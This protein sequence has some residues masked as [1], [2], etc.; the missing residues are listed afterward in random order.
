MNIQSLGYRINF[1]F[2]HFDGEVVDK[3][4]YTVIRTP[5]NFGYFWGN[6]LLFANPPQAGDLERWQGLFAQEIGTPPTINHITLG[7]DSPEGIRGE[8]APFLDAGFHLH[9][10]LIMSTQ[11]V[12]PPPKWNDA[13]TIRPIQGDHEWEQAF[14]ITLRCFPGEEFGESYV[15]FKRWEMERFR[16]MTEA[17]RGHWF[18]AFLDTKMVAGLG[19]FFEDGLGCVES[20][21]TH[22]DFQRQGLCGTL[23]FRA[24]EYAFQQLGVHTIALAAEIG[25]HAAKIYESVGF[26]VVERQIGLEKW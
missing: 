25:Y 12:Y 21:G 15:P 2:P 16:R 22:P 8:I 3:G 4:D 6:F 23:T 20:V 7:W 17:R 19:L 1:I 5:S 11:A 13:V 26:K 10:D 14:H 9:E 18:G 24:A